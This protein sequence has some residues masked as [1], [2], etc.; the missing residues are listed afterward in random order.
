[1]SDYLRAYHFKDI[2]R[3][4]DNITEISNLLFIINLILFFVIAL[5]SLRVFCLCIQKTMILFVPQIILYL[6]RYAQF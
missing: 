1:M 4:V 6:K 3:R 2:K 5:R